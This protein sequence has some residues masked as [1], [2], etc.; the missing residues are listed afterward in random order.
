MRRGEYKG[1]LMTLNVGHVVGNGPSRKHF[2]KFDQNN[3]V[4]GCNL[5]DRS[6]PLDATVVIDPAVINHIINNQIDYLPPLIITQGVKKIINKNNFDVPVSTVLDTRS[7][8][9]SSGHFATDY[10]LHRGYTHIHMWGCDSLFED[11]VESFTREQ[12]PN[13]PAN[14][15]NWKRWRNA[16]HNVFAEKKDVQFYVYTLKDFDMNFPNLHKVL[17]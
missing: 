1:I 14:S 7:K 12:I 10:L 3:F 2:K 9:N 16:W 4:V 8:G 13:E 5:S 6:L 11:T 17:L 15:K